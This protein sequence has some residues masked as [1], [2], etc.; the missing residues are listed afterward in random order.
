MNDHCGDLYEE[1][2]ADTITM[3]MIMIMTNMRMRWLP[4][5]SRQEE[6]D[7]P[8]VDLGS[9]PANFQQYIA[10]A[11]NTFKIQCTDS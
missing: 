9:M 2:M 8:L 3:M 5:Q 11:Q 7:G 10:L 4:V 1:A 6:E